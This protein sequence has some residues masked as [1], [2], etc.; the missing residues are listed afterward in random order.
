MKRILSLFV[1]LMLVSAL[2][3]SALPCSAKKIYT[4]TLSFIGIRANARDDGYEWNNY[5][6]ILTLDSITIDTDADYGLKICDGATVILKGSN[7]IKASK[8]AIFIEG[9]VIIKGEG[10]LTLIGEQG[11]YC[12]SNDRTDSLT[13]IGGKFDIT[14]SKI[15]VVSDFHSVSINNSSFNIKV[16]NGSAIKAQRLKIGI[17]T[18]ITANA[19]IVGVERLHVEGANLTVNTTSEALSGGTIYLNKLKLSAG[20]DKNSLSPVDSYDG[21]ASIKSI[22][23][24][25]GSRKSLILGERFPAFFDVIIFILIIAVLSTVI[26]LPIVIKKKKVNEAILAR[27]KAEEERIAEIKARKKAEKINRRK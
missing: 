6:D 26:V 9:K 24:Y 17:N 21:Q 12:S 25:D 10:T 22:S 19:T 3:C 23:T 4:S 27:D 11:I 15:A 20:N 18:S 2:F 5:D 13:I 16:E 8:A 7:Y 14:A 1:A